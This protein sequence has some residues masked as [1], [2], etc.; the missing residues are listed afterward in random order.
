MRRSNAAVEAAENWMVFE[1]SSCL[2]GIASNY[3]KSKTGSSL[4]RVL[5]SGFDSKEQV[6]YQ[7]MRL[8]ITS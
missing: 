1:K 4:K 8:N 5:F 6:Q 2:T 3:Y 7:H